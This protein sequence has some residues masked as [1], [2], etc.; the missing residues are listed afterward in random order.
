MYFIFFH[1]YIIRDARW[2]PV[3][4]LAKATVPSLSSMINEFVTL[5]IMLEKRN[6]VNYLNRKYSGPFKLRRIRDFELRGAFTA[7]GGIA[8]GQTPSTGNLVSTKVSLLNYEILMVQFPTLQVLV[9]ELLFL[10]IVKSHSETKVKKECSGAHGSSSGIPSSVSNFPTNSAETGKT[11][12]STMLPRKEIERDHT[13][14][15][16]EDTNFY[17]NKYESSSQYGVTVSKC[18]MYCVKCFDALP[19]EGISPSENPND[20]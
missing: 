9:N 15:P 12:D 5:E 18:H 16:G 10:A 1:Q 13:P 20:Q 14:P 7:A 4:K 3:E 11:S 19:P 8:D 6:I 17:A 2:D